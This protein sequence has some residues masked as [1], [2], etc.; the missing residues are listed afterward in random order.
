[1][2]LI[3]L[4]TDWFISSTGNSN[5]V[6]CRDNHTREITS[7]IGCAEGLSEKSGIEYIMA[8]SA[9]FPLNLIEQFR[10]QYITA[11]EECTNFNRGFMFYSVKIDSLTKEKLAIILCKK[12]ISLNTF[13]NSCIRRNK[14]KILATTPDI[15]HLFGNLKDIRH[16]SFELTLKNHFKLREILDDKAI[17]IHHW[18]TLCADYF[19]NKPYLKLKTQLKTQLKPKGDTKCKSNLN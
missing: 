7:H 3:L 13:M 12:R 11:Q 2:N 4:K 10:Y 15:L 5:I 9:K 16:L 14:D 19:M 18:I 8:H 17:T 1:M 6:F